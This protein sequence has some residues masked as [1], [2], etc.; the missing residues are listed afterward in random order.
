MLI[1]K[2]HLKGGANLR[3]YI[4]VITSLKIKTSYT[5]SNLQEHYEMIMVRTKDQLHSNM[6]FS[7]YKLWVVIMIMRVSTYSHRS[8]F[9]GGPSCF[10]QPILMHDPVSLVTLLVTSSVAHYS[11]LGSDHLCTRGRQDRLIGSSSLPVT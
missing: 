9:L 8:F 2:G 3:F 7:E 4:S 10:G 1:R 6:L 5:C 11:F